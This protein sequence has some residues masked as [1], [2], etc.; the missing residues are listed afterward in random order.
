MTVLSESKRFFLSHNGADKDLVREVA[1]GLEAA[2]RTVFFDEWSIEYGESIPGAIST[3]LEKFDAMILF[4]SKKSSA[5]AWVRE[6]FQAAVSKFVE[7]DS[8]AFVVVKLDRTEI[9]ALVAHRKWI[10]GGEGDP[11]RIVAALIGGRD[12]NH[13]PS[14]PAEDESSLVS[15]LAQTKLS[16]EQFKRDLQ[17]KSEIREAEK[18]DLLFRDE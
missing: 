12:H 9:P 8:R 10:N 17:R 2:N 7:S 5:S 16:F 14:N 6:E 1:K 11:E 13:F 4:W 3:A 18:T 15:E